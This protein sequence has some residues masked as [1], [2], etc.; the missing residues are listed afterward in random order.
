MLTWE[1]SIYIDR[2]QQ[3]V[4]DFISNPANLS[5]WSSTAVS[6]EWTSDG[7]PGVGSTAREVVKVLGRKTESIS[8]ITAW[9]PPNEYGRKMVGGP[10]A[11]EVTM[12][13][14]SKE[15]GTL[16][17]IS[18]TAEVGGFFKMAE[19]LVRKQ[20]EKQG[21]IDLKALKRLLEEGMV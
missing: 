10:V 1:N 11:G 21:E 19:G 16:L 2:P 12:K 17:T 6:G 9:D 13:L 8:E 14:D 15:D 18:G 20:T 4:W 5:L 7:P 3:E